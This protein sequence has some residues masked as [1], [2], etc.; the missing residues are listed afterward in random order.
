MKKLACRNM[1]HFRM[2]VA[3]IATLT[4]ASQAYATWV[5]VFLQRRF[6]NDHIH[7]TVAD[8]ND[9]NNVTVLDIWQNTPTTKN[10]LHK[11][12]KWANKLVM[13]NVDK[14]KDQIIKEWN[15]LYN[16]IVYRR[17][18]LHRNCAYTAGHFLTDILKIKL[19]EGIVP[20]RSI[21]FIWQ[22]Y[23]EVAVPLPGAV[24][25]KLMITLNEENIDFYDKK[26]LRTFL[27]QRYANM[28]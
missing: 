4:V 18:L 12:I 26:S 3:F 9:I 22:P 11:E 23:F 15:V 21:L 14:G 27:A 13:L 7:V 5:G 16:S 2:V 17:N 1:K 20:A 28:P 19:Y 10:V 6:F 25:K 8:D 24:I